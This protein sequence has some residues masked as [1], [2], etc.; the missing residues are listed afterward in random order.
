[1]PAPA[2]G[3]ERDLDPPPTGEDTTIALGSGDVIE[4]VDALD[5]VTLDAAEALTEVL[6]AV[7]VGVVV[8]GPE[9]EVVLANTAARG[10]LAGLPGSM[11]AHAVAP[12]A[13][14]D[15][16]PRTFT[17]STPRPDGSARRLVFTATPVPTTGTDSVTAAITAALARHDL[18]PTAL[19]PDVI[20]ASEPADDAAGPRRPVVTTLRDLVTERQQ[21]ARPA[22]GSDT[23]RSTP[24]ESATLRR[25][26][27]MAERR[28]RATM[29]ASPIGTALLTPH[30]RL[31]QVNRA[32]ARILGRPAQDLVGT[33]L[34]DLTHP[35]DHPREAPLVQQ[36]LGRKIA[37]YELEKRLVR[38]TGEVIWVRATMAPVC[39]DD[40]SVLHLVLQAQD[41]SETRQAVEM[42]THQ[43]MRDSLTGLANRARCVGRIQESLDRAARRRDPQR[44]VAV[45]CC[46]LDDF[47]VVNDSVGP[48]YGDA[49]LVEVAGRIRRVIDQR[50]IAAR[51]AGDEF[52][53]V[54]D[55]VRHAEDAVNL[56][57]EVLEAVRLPVTVDGRVVV[58]TMSIG[59]A[60]SAPT[61]SGG[62]PVRQD[63]LG[64]LRDAGTA[65]HEAKRTD[66]GGC[67]VMDEQL[68]RRTVE[69]L[70]LESQLRTGLDQGEL[71]LH[72][73][74]IVDLT[75]GAI[76]GREALVRWQHPEL[77]LLPP[78]R[79]LT[80]AEE[81]GMIADLGR[82]VIHEAARIAAAT[83]HLGYVAINVSPSQ[84][85]GTSLADD[86]EAALTAAGLP[87]S[88]LVVELT[89]SVMLG[90]AP[91][92]RSQ[93]ERL[94]ALGVRLVV[95]DF[96]TG[97]SALSHLRDL[98]VSGI[99]I[100]RSFTQGLG[101]DSQCERI[102]EALTGL[103][104]GLGVDLVAEGV[105]TEGQAQ[106]LADIGCVHAQGYLFGRPEPASA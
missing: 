54:R 84:V 39:E 47:R 57:R 72:V 87:P 73:Q 92:E 18:P 98:P 4:P 55:G 66:R 24:D 49:I 46:D 52:V 79:F 90:A 63:A 16:A 68:R 97:F 51:L 67:Q 37:S 19:D 89:E 20:P 5:I 62:D 11:L 13:R 6:D 76:V 101:E 31:L 41:V 10:M 105:E 104:Q 40:G 50:D 59:I 85:R 106:H 86:V 75:S 35:D 69:R 33:G 53:I 9:G 80:V 32:L 60:L 78:N 88:R 2:R 17:W 23:P 64:L 95:D 43:A 25:S 14:P 82:W 30:G 34:A 27:A 1:M 83:P 81:T 12:V 26:L 77:G 65:L 48:P 45:L 93:L 100:D 21:Q 8:H 15:G 22:N 38:P 70:D 56:A 99:K 28:L 7:T 96:G 74:P 42:L 91:E 44:R 58:P 61:P 103:A 3:R 102:V 94:D 71:R 29:D 36:L